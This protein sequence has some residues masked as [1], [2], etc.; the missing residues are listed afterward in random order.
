[1][2]DRWDDACWDGNNGTA[3]R[4]RT[5]SLARNRLTGAAASALGMVARVC[6]RLDLSH[7][8]LGSECVRQVAHALAE[9]RQRVSVIR[10]QAVQAQTAGGLAMVELVSQL[11]YLELLDLRDNDIGNE[12]TLCCTA[13][14]VCKPGCS[15]LGRGHGVPGGRSGWRY[16]AA[17]L[18]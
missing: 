2:T 13:L 4:R 16:A 12:G 10:L 11:P 7:N 18:T 15:S 9:T 6:K 5:V 14:P 8:A 17:Q 1:M 3:G